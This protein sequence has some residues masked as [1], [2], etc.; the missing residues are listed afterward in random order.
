MKNKRTRFLIKLLIEE[1]LPG[2]NYKQEFNV[3]NLAYTSS[4][5]HCDCEGLQREVEEL[6]WQPMYEKYFT[7]GRYLK[8]I[9][10]KQIGV[11]EQYFN[12]RDEKK[13]IR[14]KAYK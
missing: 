12:F 3:F 5:Y 13:P 8:S 4:N 7:G 14:R 9:M 11:N 6:L 2:T 1:R 10:V